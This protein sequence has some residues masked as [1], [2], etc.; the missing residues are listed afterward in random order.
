MNIL[1][2]GCGRV[3]SSLASSFSQ[4]GHTVIILDINSTAFQRLP[5][6]FKGTAIV[7]NGTD[8]DTLTGANVNDTDVFLA[9]TQGDNRNLM[10]AQ[11]AKHIFKVPRVLSRV[12]DK[13]RADIFAKLGIETFSSTYIMS[14]MIEDIVINPE[15]NEEKSN[16]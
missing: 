7:G 16:L 2:M 3:G 1:I 15:T 10:A 5:A 13:N 8:Q 12:Y 14:N 9:L 11:I 6:D 4:K